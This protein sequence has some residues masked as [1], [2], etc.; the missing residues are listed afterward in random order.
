[1]KGSGFTVVELAVV[2]TAV[3]LFVILIVITLQ[4]PRLQAN[5]VNIKTYLYQ[6]MTLAAASYDL[7][8]S[9]YNVCSQDNNP[10]RSRQH[11]NTGKSD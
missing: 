9:Y 4:S 8:G 3:T 2:V 5:D 10:E 7:N 6:I 1:M 11:R